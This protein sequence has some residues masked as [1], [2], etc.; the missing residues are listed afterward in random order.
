MNKSVVVL[1]FARAPEVRLV[2][3][4]SFCTHLDIANGNTRHD[5]GIVDELEVVGESRW[6]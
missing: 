5:C 2:S 6:C 1:V 4:E 3:G